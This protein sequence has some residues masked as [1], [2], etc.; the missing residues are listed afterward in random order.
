M[1]DIF[2]GDSGG[3]DGWIGWNAKTCKWTIN[4]DPAEPKSMFV[5][6][7]SFGEGWIRFNPYDAVFP[8]PEDGP[9]AQPDET[10][11]KAWRVRVFVDEWLNFSFTSWSAYKA[12]KKIAPAFRD[13]PD[14]KVTEVKVTDSLLKDNKGNAGP[15]LEVVGF[16]DDPSLVPPAAAS[17][18][19]AA[20]NDRDSIF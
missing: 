16:V 7:R 18:P 1:S 10:Y 20:E 19:A 4:G 2:S 13:Q 9:I 8:H 15:G 17:A 14:G 5:D 12:F 6:A 11:K 3:G